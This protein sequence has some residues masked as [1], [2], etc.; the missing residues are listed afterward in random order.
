MCSIAWSNS[1]FDGMT[2]KQAANIPYPFFKLCTR[3]SFVITLP[4]GYPGEGVA[5]PEHFT[6]S[7]PKQTGEGENGTEIAQAD[8]VCIKE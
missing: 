3:T 4:E 7:G 5:H 6:T 1:A 8:G 2:Q